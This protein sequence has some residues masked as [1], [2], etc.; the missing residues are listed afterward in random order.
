MGI[1]RYTQSI[2][3]ALTLVPEGF[4]VSH[5]G[6]EL[7]YG[8]WYVKIKREAD[9]GIES[10]DVPRWTSGAHQPVAIALCIAALKA[11]ESTNEEA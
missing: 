1:P 2:D 10:D 9:Y 5:I 7:K 8:G 11:Q 6:R 4:Y 3:S